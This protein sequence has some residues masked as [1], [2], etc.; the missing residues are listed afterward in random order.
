MTTPR[1]DSQVAAEA[2][3]RG[4][5]ESTFADLRADWL[6]IQNDAQAAMAGWEAQ[7][8]DLVA[9]ESR[10][11]DAGKW[12][13][14][15]ADYLGVI[16]RHRD[17]LVHSKMLAWFL[18]PCAR[19]GLGTRVLAGVLRL[20][21]PDAPVPSRL[22]RANVFTEV[23]L[24]ER[25][26]DIVVDAP[27]LYLVIEN[28]VD[29]DESDG[30]C[31]YYYKHVRRADAR[32]ILLSSDGRTSRD[33]PEFQPLRFSQVARVLEE[34]LRDAPAPGGGGSALSGRRIVTD[35]LETLRREFDEHR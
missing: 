29:A 14:G 34:A 30:Q 17:E 26:L 5:D 1:W 6:R 12:M 23:V 11:R 4:F 33:T 22:E 20:T 7:L 28:K 2:S 8:A 15:R 19:H 3:G 27:G 18:D 9:E 21:H 25:R 32:F 31:A 13:H 16:D 24:G 10:L 35:Y